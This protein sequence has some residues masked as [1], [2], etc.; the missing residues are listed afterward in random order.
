MADCLPTK[1]TVLILAPAGE[2]ASVLK[3]VLVKDGLEC[4]VCHS[5]EELCDRI[6]TGAGAALIA[7]EVFSMA[8][9]ARLSEA[10]DQQPEWSD[11]P[12]IV[13]ASIGLTSDKTWAII[14]T[15]VR[16]LN[17]TILERPV[18]KRTL[19]S[20]VHS[21]LR[22]RESQ[23]R[24]AEE[25]KRRREAEASLLSANKEL[26]AFSYSVAHDLRNPLRSIRGIAD[27]IIE[28]CS[29]ELSEECQDYFR[30]IHS[31]AQRMNTIIDDML[32]LSKIS[33]KQMDISELDLSEMVRSAIGQL[34]AEHP[35]RVVTVS[36]EEGLRVRADRQ[37]MSVAL[38]NLLSNAWKYTAK[39]ERPRVEFGSFVKEN[40]QRVFFI[41]DNGAGFDMKHAQKL[42]APFQRLHADSDFKGTG[43]G[44]AIV[45][46]VIMRHG[47]S[48]WAESESGKGATFFFTLKEGG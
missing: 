30:M 18:L 37:L 21:A 8:D 23:Y 38:T 2:D 25:L 31:G 29:Q 28:D 5:F 15:G 36:I 4:R 45:E 12:V 48:V 47:G 34:K 9:I 32:A 41:R 19:L 40:E 39:T 44:L 3:N 13:M 22:S 1:H 6:S 11:L 26:E 17:T 20:A 14:N 7:E 16:G 33:R 10:I 42:F 24:I 46:R 43:V 35:D 27:I